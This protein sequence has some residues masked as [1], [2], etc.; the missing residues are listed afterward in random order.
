MDH[1]DLW[2]DGG[3][4]DGEAGQDAVLVISEDRRRREALGR[5]LGGLGLDVVVV[6]STDA[7]LARLAEAPERFE[8]VVA[9]TRGEASELLEAVFE[10]S[11]AARR[12]VVA[13]AH[14]AI[15]L[16]GALDPEIIDE[17]IVRPSGLEPLMQLARRAAERLLGAALTPSD[18]ALI[19]ARPTSPQPSR[20]MS[21]PLSRLGAVRAVV[22]TLERAV[23]ARGPAAERHARRVAAYAGRIAR[24][25]GLDGATRFDIEHA[26]LLHDVGLI[27]TPDAY[28]REA[29]APTPAERASIE[30]HPIVG[31][32]ILLG[33]EGL[34]PAAELV[35]A[36]HERPDGTGYPFGRRGL[37]VPLGAS[38]VAAADALDAMSSPRPHR[39]AC[40]FD[41]ALAELAAVAG[42]QV[43]EVVVDAMLEVAPE[44]WLE[45]SEVAV[46]E[47][48]C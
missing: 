24:D 12:L 13:S 26:A 11:P 4:G 21:E 1:V 40:A 34:R 30:R 20:S 41:E 36:H 37:D 8:L 28:E 44:E 2:G 48:P 45:L 16:A 33:C 39:A 22:E 32:A 46:E 35:L 31:H 29:R 10:L 17:I 43:H 23:A 19:A 5:A 6:G 42:L 38:I 14:D 18:A 9:E 25:L 27:G 15:R 3:D 47:R 7:G